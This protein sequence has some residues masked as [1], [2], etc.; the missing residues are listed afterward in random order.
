MMED[1]TNSNRQPYETLC[2]FLPFLQEFENF[3][4]ANENLAAFSLVNSNF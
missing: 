4:R 2:K 1:V 3:L